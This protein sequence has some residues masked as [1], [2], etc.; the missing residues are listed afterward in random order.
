[1]PCHRVRRLCRERYLLLGG[2]IQKLLDPRFCD[3]C[4]PC[5]AVMGIYT[6]S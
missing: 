6:A 5:V 2:I 3:P 4:A 1:M